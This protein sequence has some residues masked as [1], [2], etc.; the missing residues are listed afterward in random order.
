MLEASVMTDTRKAIKIYVR[1][2]PAGGLAEHFSCDSTGMDMERED[3]RLS[4]PFGADTFSQVVDNELIIRV[5]IIASVVL[6]CGR[7]LDDFSAVLEADGV[8]SYNVQPTDVVDITADVRQEI[9]LAYP[10]I[11]RCRKDCKGLC[12]RCGRNLNTGD[13]EHQAAGI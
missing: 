8:L 13:C 12:P 3:I 7:C 11:P 6:T 4:A 2:I 1:N 5:D 10:M 9:L